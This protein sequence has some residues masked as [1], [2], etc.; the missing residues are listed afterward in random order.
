[1]TKTSVACKPSKNDV[2][3]GRGHQCQ[4]HQGNRFFRQV[5]D[6]NKVNYAQAK[7]TC[8]KDTIAK[9]VFQTIKNQ[10]PS[11]NFLKK[12]E[13]GKYY[14]SSDKDAIVKIKQALRENNRYIK[15]RMNIQK[16][17]EKR[18]AKITLSRANSDS[19]V[20][21]NDVM[22]LTALILDIN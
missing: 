8:D 4:N 11:G 7:K 9:F 5:V 20:T 22:K 2:L 14:D 19:V 13:D 18:N 3:F 6:K 17:E 16:V 21:K 15:E 12:A 10:K 1:M